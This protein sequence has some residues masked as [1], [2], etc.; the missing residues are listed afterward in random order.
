[1]DV[2]I[3]VAS[4]TAQNVVYIDT[5]GGIDMTRLIQIL[6][7]KQ[8]ATGQV[9]LVDLVNY[10]VSTLVQSRSIQANLKSHCNFDR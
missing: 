5:G 8:P 2:A 3:A 6:E 10:Y 4:T 1:M 7:C 9:N